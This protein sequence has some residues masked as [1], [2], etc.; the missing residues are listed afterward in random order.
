MAAAVRPPSFSSAATA[1]TTSPLHCN[2]SSNFSATTARV[3]FLRSEP[4]TATTPESTNHGSTATTQ[5]NQRT[6]QSPR[7][8]ITAATTITTA[9]FHHA[10]ILHTI[11]HAIVHALGPAPHLHCIL[12]HRSA[13][14]SPC[15]PENVTATPLAI[16]V[17]TSSLTPPRSREHERTTTFVAGKRQPQ[18][19]SRSSFIGEECES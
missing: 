19:S 9:S 16:T 2:N 7:M 14:P 12:Q 1:C 18:P 17:A 15:R 3:H 13:P 6:H 10:Y 11:L 4:V 8:N 5:V